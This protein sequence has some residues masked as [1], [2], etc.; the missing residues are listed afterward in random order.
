MSRE[1]LV[2]FFIFSITSILSAQAKDTSENIN[3]LD[4]NA[5]VARLNIKTA[6]LDR[7]LRI[8]GEPIK[9]SWKNQTFSK[10]N[11]PGIYNIDYPNEF[12]VLM[13]IGKVQELR[14]HQPGYKFLGKVQVG[15]TLEEFL[16]VLGKPKQIIE[17]R[18]NE[19]KDRVLY[20]DIEGEKGTCYY[21]N[22]R[23]GARVFFINNK[24]TALY[25]TRNDPSGRR[26]SRKANTE[27][28]TKPK[29]TGVEALAKE[30]IQL[31]TN[32]DFSKAAEN[33]DGAMKKAAPPENLRQVW[34]SLVTQYGQFEKQLDRRIKTILI[35]KAIIVTCQFEKAIVD[36]QVTYNTSKEISG[37][38]ILST[39]S[40]NSYQ[41]PD[42][43]KSKSFS[44]QEIKVGSGQWSLPG[45]LTLPRGQGPFPVVV[46][47]HGSGPH[48][49]DETVGANKP[50]RDLAYG[51]ADKGVAVL[52]Y[53]KRTK[54]FPLQTTALA[55][56]LTVKEETIDDSLAAV[57]LLRNTDKIDLGKIF[58]IGHSLGGYVIPKIGKLD[59]KIAGFIIMAG[60]ARPLEDVALEQLN[61]IF[62]IDGVIT[63]DEKAN[64]EKLK[65]QIAKVK[66]P[67]L[68]PTSPAIELPFGIPAAY[69]L[70]LRGYQ[71]AE[72]AK[73]LS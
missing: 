46:L 55:N 52:R 73:E 25:V 71:P 67:K 65:D 42:Y 72:M 34:D 5:K 58:V 23:K 68:S 53:E 27:L 11:L 18:K 30:F 26:R 47:V 7:V 14:H 28:N 37:F 35:Y 44:E 29:V 1:T 36:L 59:S 60:S 38:H 63:N 54:A 24:A 22:K 61:Y 12:S 32:G 49:Q 50:F 20:K 17:G 3:S 70:D 56:T 41:V 9:Y 6:T 19:F 39:R 69:W 45:T 62:S 48:D 10:N 8:F 2:L 51:L 16:D 31:L 33:F 57:A 43:I 13:I 21:A 64:L 66:D 40:K 4:I 15:S